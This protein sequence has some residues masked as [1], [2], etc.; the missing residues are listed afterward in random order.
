MTKFV[1]RRGTLGVAIEATRGVAIAPTYW[2]PW[3]TM[4]FF[5]R[6]TQQ[7]EEQGLGNIADSDSIYVT[8]RFAE[9]E[10]ESQIYDKGLGYIITSLLGAVPVT[11]G[12]GPYTHTFTL[13]STNQPKSLCLYWKDADRSYMFKNAVV[14]SLKVSI[15][16]AGI[17]NY[18][19]EFKSKVA[20]DWTS[21]T[22]DFTSLG[23][24]FLHQHSE[25]RLASTIGALSGS[26]AISLKK[27]ELMIDRNVILDEVI[28]TSEPEDIL[29]Q[30]LSVEGSLELNLEDD[31]YR[32]YM[33][34]GT[35][36]A[37]EFKLNGGTSSSLQLQFPRLDFSEWEPDYTL[38]EIAKQKINF[39]ANYD[40]ANALAIISTAVLINSKTSY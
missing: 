9:G 4:S 23:S 19:V 7:R 8:L 13:S 17:V 16:P 31:T 35:Y 22:P 12:A 18:T 14:K 28:G 29:G 21:Q 24:K 11:T 27:F 1:G 32:N 25:F 15:E 26:T 2:L 3:V 38:N 33:L 39:K 34:N 20:S 36:K 10:I 40:S 30:Q 37:C 6:A 5:D